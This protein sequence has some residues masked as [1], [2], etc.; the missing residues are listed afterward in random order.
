MFV[1]MCV[2]KITIEQNNNKIII[3][4]YKNR[5]EVF[6]SFSTVN[7]R[8]PRI[9]RNRCTI[10]I[11]LWMFGSTTKGKP[12]VEMESSEIPLRGSA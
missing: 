10:I 8:R 3:L 5:P 12:L 7:T 9:T 6:I 2:C 11:G 1:C 4:F